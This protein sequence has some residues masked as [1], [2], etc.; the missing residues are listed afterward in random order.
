MASYNISSDLVLDS[1]L[2]C[3]ICSSENIKDT[4]EGY[5]CGDC[6]VVLEI[7]KLQYHHP[8]DDNIVQYAPLGKTQIGTIR[9]RN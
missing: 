6:G 5:V 1:D 2:S 7:Q 8:Y 4:S 3:D 9:E